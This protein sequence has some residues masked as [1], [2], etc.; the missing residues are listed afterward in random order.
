MLSNLQIIF[1]H[2]ITYFKAPFSLFHC[3]I[4]YNK[5]PVLRVL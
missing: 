4:S 3:T 2:K 5:I 1:I